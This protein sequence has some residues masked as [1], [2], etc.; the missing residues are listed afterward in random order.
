MEIFNAKVLKCLDKHAPVVTFTPRVKLNPLL[1][2]ETV[3]WIRERD[4]ALRR[5]KMTRDSADT[6]LYRKLRNKVVGLLRKDKQ[7]AD[8]LDYSNPRK[9]W[10]AFN[11][12][13][14]ATKPGP[15]TKLQ[16]GNKLITDKT[17]MANELNDFF[18]SKVKKLKEKILTK[19]CPYDPVEHL[20]SHLPSNLPSLNLVSV[21]ESEVEEVLTVLKSSKSCGCDKLSN[22]VLKAGKGALKT[23]LTAIFN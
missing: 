2:K 4:K 1:S 23:P 6:E 9:A 22:F 7:R 15:P 14:R 3:K 5:S 17:E 11:S 12:L 13:T 21:T 20:K 16:A 8:S 10:A 18:I 19:E